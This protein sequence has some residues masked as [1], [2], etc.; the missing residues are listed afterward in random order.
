[1]ETK[2]K[3]CEAIHIDVQCDRNDHEDIACGG[4]L[5]LGSS[6]YIPKS[7]SLSEYK[8]FI[9]ECLTKYNRPYINMV[10]TQKDRLNINYLHDKK[11]IDDIIRLESI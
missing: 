2:I 6:F 7:V 11:Q 1:M 4:S 3:T 5:M 8:D 9:R 10:V